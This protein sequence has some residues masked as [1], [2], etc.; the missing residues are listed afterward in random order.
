MTVGKVIFTTNFPERIDG[1]LLDRCRRIELSQPT[2]AQWLPR[3]Q[4][5]LAAEQVHFPEASLG[6]ALSGF[7]STRDWLRELWTVVRRLRSVTAPATSA[8][9]ATAPV[10]PARSTP[11]NFVVLNS[12]DATL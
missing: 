6:A 12:P 1:A 10:V 8:T 5:I 7:S 9:A 3:A 11:R 4:A 2:V